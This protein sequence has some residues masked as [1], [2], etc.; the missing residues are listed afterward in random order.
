[1]DRRNLDNK[2]KIWIVKTGD[3]L[4]HKLNNPNNICECIIAL[5]SFSISIENRSSYL[6]G[7]KS[8]NKETY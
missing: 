6:S 7:S 4:E 2:A 1:M 5:Y 8:V 3:R